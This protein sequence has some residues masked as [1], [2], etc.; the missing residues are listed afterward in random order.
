MALADRLDEEAKF[1]EAVGALGILRLAFW[2]TVVL[3]IRAAARSEH[4]AKDDEESM[5]VD[6]Q[7]VLPGQA[8]LRARVSQAA[9]SASDWLSDI[10]AAISGKTCSRDHDTRSR[11]SFRTTSTMSYTAS[12]DGPPSLGTALKLL[13][14]FTVTYT[15]WRI[16]S[17]PRPRPEL[18][19]V[20]ILVLG[21]IGRS[22]RMMYHTES[23]ATNKFLTYLVGYGG[24]FESL[25]HSGR[26][27]PW[28]GC[29]YPRH[30]V[31]ESVLSSVHV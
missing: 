14:A 24:E 23:F 26:N 8:S 27:A 11:S 3:G 19:S 12:A 18:R 7:E 10:T 25:G 5:V 17:R 22:P 28:S 6:E 15:L 20:A 16:Y 21:D 13:L 30:G 2:E 1:R 4:E 29:G 31:R 9:K